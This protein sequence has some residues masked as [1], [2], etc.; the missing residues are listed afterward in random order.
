MKAKLLTTL[1]AAAVVG[2][3]SGSTAGA[4]VTVGQLSPLHPADTHC[5]GGPFDAVQPTV[6]AGNSYVVPPTGGVSS[7][8]ATS[9]SNNASTDMGQSLLMKFWRP[10]GGSMYM[11]VGHDGPRSP[12]PGPLNTFSA[13]RIPVNAGDVLGI[14][15]RRD[16]RWGQSNG[17]AL[18]SPGDHHFIT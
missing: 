3:A 12:T 4:A 14:T 8:V 5:N 13:L 18:R 9:W 16:L 2:L 6:T 7:W 11:A 17:C 15:P 1:A 10:L